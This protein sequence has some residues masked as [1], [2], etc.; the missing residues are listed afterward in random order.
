MA[1]LD[2]I[3]SAA[4]G[5]LLGGVFSAIKLF[6]AYKEKKLMFAH[7][8]NMAEQD[9]KNM[10]KEIEVAKVKGTLELEVEESRGDAM[11]LT[12]AIN[13]EAD[14]KAASPWVQDFKSMTR[15]VL[16]YLLVIMAFGL[17]LA[18]QANPWAEEI[19][20]M[21]STAVTF[22]FGDRPRRTR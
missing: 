13:A 8:L 12:A 9:R 4:S 3:G 22:W 17:V 14:S 7:E 18:D 6:G 19:V 1:I 20:F 15:P 5:G 21:A 2:L 16:T 10:D 11:A